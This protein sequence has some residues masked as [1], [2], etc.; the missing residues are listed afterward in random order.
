MGATLSF[1]GD[2]LTS[3]KAVLELGSGGGAG[4]IVGL[5]AKVG[6]GEFGAGG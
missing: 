3:L 6:W 2:E 5:T 1:G 4:R